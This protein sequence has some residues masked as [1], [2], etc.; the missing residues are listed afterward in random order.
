[1]SKVIKHLSIEEYA[2]KI[3]TITELGMVTI[4]LGTV[5]KCNQ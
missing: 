4:L 1:M 2:L 5:N 3:C